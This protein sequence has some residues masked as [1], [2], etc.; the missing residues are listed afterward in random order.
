MIGVACSS[1]SNGIRF[2]GDRLEKEV[3]MNSSVGIVILA[4]GLGKR[5]KSDR[6]KVLHEIVGR[7]MIEYILDVA[8]RVVGANVVVVVGH[9]SEVVQEIVSRSYDVRFAIQP[10]QRGT[11][12]AVMCAMPVIPDHVSSVVVLCG[13]VP[14]IQAATIDQLVSD[15]LLHHRDV[16]ALAVQVADPT[17]YGRMIM[18]SDGRLTAIIE[19]ADADECQKQIDV[20]NTGFYVIEKAFLDQAL[21]RLDANNAQNE[22]YLT[23]II[24]YGHRNG[25]N[26]GVMV[27][28]DAQQ[29]MGVNSR[30]ELAVAENLMKIRSCKKS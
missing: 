13:D 24:G 12:H 16:T 14:L 20:I 22:I 2:I 3:T 18:D 15:H 19:Q 25:R 10:E 7:P 23:D 26:I 5:M 6:A 27:G 29:F 9:Q 21:P 28:E 1:S 11:G 30:E 17:G 8:T 4:A